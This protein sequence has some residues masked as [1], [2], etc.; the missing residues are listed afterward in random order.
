MENT[1]F[2]SGWIKKEILSILEKHSS[3]ETEIRETLR[4]KKPFVQILNVS[5]DAS[6]LTVSDTE[7]V[8]DISVNPVAYEK[9]YRFVWIFLYIVISILI[10]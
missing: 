9:L 3:A 6:T 2:K 10:L 7:V 5:Q 4:H 1:W 8:V